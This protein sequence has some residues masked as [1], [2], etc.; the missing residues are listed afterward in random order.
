M[1]K[2]GTLGTR[3]DMRTLL[4]T[5]LLLSASQSNP[6]TWPGAGGGAGGAGRAPASGA[7]GPEFRE[8]EAKTDSQE[9]PPPEDRRP[10]DVL[11]ECR[12]QRVHG[13]L[14]KELE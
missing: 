5:L 6:Q 3:A 1:K 9:N 13:S 14:W 4:L 12:D 11:V 2:N 10:E 8:M 7:G